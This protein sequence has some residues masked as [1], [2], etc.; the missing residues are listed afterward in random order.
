MKYI[1]QFLFFL[2]PAFALAQPAIPNGDFENWTNFGAYENPDSWGT[3]NPL[4]SILGIKTTTK[5][6]GAEAHSGSFAIK[7]ES[8]TIPAQG[9][10]P[11]IAATGVINPTTR[12][13]DGG[14]PFSN[15]P[16]SL[17]GWY[18]YFPA[19]GDTGS[20]EVSLYRWNAS[21]GQ[22]ELVGRAAFNPSSTISVYTAFSVDFEYS[23]GLNPDTMVIVLLSSGGDNIRTGSKMLLDDL[24]LSDFG[25]SVSEPETPGFTLYPNPAKDQLQIQAAD[26]FF[27]CMLSLV[28]T[29]GR[30]CLQQVF[31]QNNKCI[32]LAD[33]PSGNYQVL[34]QA[35]KSGI[36]FS[37]S[38]Q[39]QR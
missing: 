5:A 20:V 11:G 1:S 24:S 38:L 18:Q 39:L 34:L 14:I 29:D 19:A 13:I 32:K 3:I 12:N 30:I 25:T 31:D 6:T 27:P 15:R 2:I 16:V 23:S 36:R 10:A 33:I 21:Q 37:R 4:T 9:N 35:K 22:R 8:K 7:L 26:E 17:R 28:A